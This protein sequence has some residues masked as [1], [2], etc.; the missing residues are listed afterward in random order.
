MPKLLFSTFESFSFL[1][2]TLSQCKLYEVL[3]PKARIKS[4]Y[5]ALDWFKLFAISH[6]LTL[7]NWG[8]SHILLVERSV[9]FSR[10]YISK[11]TF[12]ICSQCTWYKFNLDGVLCLL[13][14]SS[15]EVWC[16][17]GDIVVYVLM[18]ME[19]S[20]HVQIISIKQCKC[21]P[22]KFTV[23]NLLYILYDLEAIK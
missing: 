1:P 17:S 13:L 21:D 23:Y 22:Y 20:L 16:D 5:L 12:E 14:L 9:I 8:V 4:L 19:F 7:D 6:R 18:K 11:C 2:T 10:E 3:P 15:W